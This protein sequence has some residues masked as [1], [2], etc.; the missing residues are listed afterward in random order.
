[1]ITPATASDFADRTSKFSS[2]AHLLITS[3]GRRGNSPGIE[4]CPQ[5]TPMIPGASSAGGI[6]WTTLTT[7]AVPANAT[8]EWFAGSVSGMFR[9]RISTP[10]TGGTVT[11]LGVRPEER[12]GWSRRPSPLAHRLVRRGDTNYWHETRC[13]LIQRWCS[14]STR[15][16][17]TS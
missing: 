4:C 14:C 1:M 16:C 3:P 12:R 11:V 6:V 13:F 10:V 5:K 15:S 8:T 7:V 17:A 2:V 9:A